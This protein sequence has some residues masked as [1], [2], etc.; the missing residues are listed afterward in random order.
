MRTSKILNRIQSVAA[1]NKSKTFSNIG[2]RQFHKICRW[3]PRN[4]LSVFAFHEPLFYHR[5]I[6]FEM[7]KQLTDLHEHIHEF[8]DDFATTKSQKFSSLSTGIISF[9]LLFLKI[10]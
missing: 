1:V 6:A 7:N 8:F 3:K 2:K 9:F 10:S 4:D 5:P